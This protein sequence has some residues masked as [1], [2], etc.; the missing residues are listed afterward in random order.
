MDGTHHDEP[1]YPKHIETS[2]LQKGVLA[3]GSALTA[4][5]APWR[6]GM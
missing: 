3:V 1:L 6:D 2:P 5:A 4:L